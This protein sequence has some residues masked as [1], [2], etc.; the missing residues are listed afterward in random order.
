MGGRRDRR[1]LTGGLSAVDLIVYPFLALVVRLA[2]RTADFVKDDDSGPVLYVWIER[3]QR[4]P[5]VER[6]RPPHWK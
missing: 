1:Y 5:F 2:G 4:L 3:M 6:T